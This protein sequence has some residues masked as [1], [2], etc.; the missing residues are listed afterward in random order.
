[1]AVGLHGKG[2]AGGGIAYL[3]SVLYC[4]NGKT[5]QPYC[6]FSQFQC[7]TLDF[8]VGRSIVILYQEVGDIEHPR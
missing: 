3:E 8:I 6:S 2:G 7:K 4:D 1:M 5:Y